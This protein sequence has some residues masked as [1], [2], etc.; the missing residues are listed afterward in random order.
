MSAKF[1]V[2]SSSF[3]RGYTARST[4]FGNMCCITE[5]SVGGTPIDEITLKDSFY[6]IQDKKDEEVSRSG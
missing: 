4:S 3:G 6:A 5:R 1:K 2:L